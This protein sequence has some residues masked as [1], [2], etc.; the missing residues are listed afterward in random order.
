MPP[1]SKIQPGYLRPLIPTNAPIRG[2]HWTAVMDDIERVIMPGVTHWHSPQFHAYFAAANSYPAIVADILSDAIGSIGFS[3]I[4]SP[5]CTELEVVTMDWLGKML[6]L[7]KQFLFEASGGIGGGVIQGTASEATLTAILSARQK[8]IFNAKSVDKNAEQS[9]VMSKLVVYGSRLAHSSV[10][11]AA[12][13]AGVKFHSLE[14]DEEW[15]LRLEA[16][17][18]AVEKDRVKGLIPL[19]VVATLGTTPCCSFDNLAEL[20]NFDTIVGYQW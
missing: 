15:S 7:P 5:A 14:P 11:K 20:G 10:E 2:E 12:M 16:V 4:A 6:G 18:A 17:I 9:L 1:K 3:W 8:A 13:I 19:A